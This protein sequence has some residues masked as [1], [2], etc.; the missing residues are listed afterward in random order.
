MPRSLE[1]TK[2]SVGDRLGDNDACHRPARLGADEAGQCRNDPDRGEE[3]KEC[4]IGG[5]NAT[6][7]ATDDREFGAD[8]CGE[9]LR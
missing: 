5:E 7:V 8:L 4:A 2:S 9:P 6:K 1:R 3:T